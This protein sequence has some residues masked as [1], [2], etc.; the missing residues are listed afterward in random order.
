MEIHSGSRLVIASIGA[1]H[2]SRIITGSDPPRTITSINIH[3]PSIL[4]FILEKVNRRKN[5]AYVVRI[6]S[7]IL[8][9]SLS[10]SLSSEAVE[11]GKR[12]TVKS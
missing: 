7:Y 1:T 12:V 4:A 2:S 5:P 3:I 9:R 11:E 6:C 8:I 10:F